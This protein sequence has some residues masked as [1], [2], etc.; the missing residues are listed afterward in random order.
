MQILIY[1]LVFL[2]ATGL[3]FWEK[4]I[5]HFDNSIFKLWDQ[6]FWNPSISWKRK[7]KNGDKEQ[8]PRFLFSDT[9]LAWTVDAYHLIKAIIMFLIIIGFQ[10][11]LGYNIFWGIIISILIYTF[12]FGVLFN[13]VLD[14]NTTFKAYIFKKLSDVKGLFSLIFTKIKNLFKNKKK[15]ND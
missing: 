6:N 15:S 13:M 2:I 3:A 11:I 1:V 8:G 14:T 4:L 9:F 12:T 10:V 5:H 7:Y